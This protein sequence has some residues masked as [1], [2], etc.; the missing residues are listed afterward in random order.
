M[1]EGSDVAL[2]PTL[3]I[4]VPTSPLVVSPLGGEV[5]KP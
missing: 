4:T 1:A 5:R 3:V 2:R